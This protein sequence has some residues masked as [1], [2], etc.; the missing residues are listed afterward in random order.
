MSEQD[1]YNVEEDASICNGLHIAGNYWLDS[2][3]GDDCL[4]VGL[5]LLKKTIARIKSFRSLSEDTQ[6]ELVVQKRRYGLPL[7]AEEQK[8]AQKHILI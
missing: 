3:E 5:E 6:R 7:S 1:K 8:F 2:Q 4:V